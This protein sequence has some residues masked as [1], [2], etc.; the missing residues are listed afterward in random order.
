[1][2]F[3]YFHPVKICFDVDFNIAL[4]ALLK[5]EL[6]NMRCL[7]VTSQ[8]FTKKGISTKV[9]NIFTDMIIFD[10]VLPNPELEFLQVEKEKLQNKYDAIIALG[11]GSV[12]DSAKFFALQ[13]EVVA[14]HGELHINGICNAKPIF[15]LP[16]TAG[17]SSEL[18]KWATI[19]D[20]KANIKYSLSHN[21]LYPQ[22][23]LYD[24]KF[25]LSL[26]R[27]IT[28]YTA[29]DTL[30]HAIESI[31]NRNANPLSTH[32][33]KAAIELIIEYLPQ[34]CENLNSM[35]LRMQIALACI[36]AGL[37]F[38]NTQTALAH[39]ISYPI[40]IAFN[41]PHGLACSFSLPILLD[42]I[43][44]K[45]ADS[46]LQPYKQAIKTLF[47]KLNIP[48]NPCDYGLDSIMVEK[49]FH[50]LNERA[51][52]GLLDIEMVKRR[53]LAYLK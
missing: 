35:H 50:S 14:Q 49:I 38:S 40:T 10:S 31:W 20:K 43:N 39:A 47:I 11:G 25:M 13:N 27:E 33:A 34:L 23:A 48:T 19:W 6:K 53:F 17:T 3:D 1:M 37:A 7:F 8:S 15:A 29:L 4:E 51:K 28:I 32:H 24:I 22:V 41:I 46:I 36:Y 18:T 2:S 26:P 16:T 9:K 42:C 52:N 12:L 21:C 30:S 44:D 5:H 45:K